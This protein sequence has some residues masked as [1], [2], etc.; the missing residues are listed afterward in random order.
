MWVGAPGSLKKAHREGATVS[1]HRRHPGNSCPLMEWTLVTPQDSGTDL[2]DKR[3]TRIEC[4]RTEAEAEG[5]GRRGWRRRPWDTKALVRPPHPSVG[6]IG[7]SSFLLTFMG[8]IA[9]PMAPYAKES[10]QQ[11]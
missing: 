5:G 4:R 3:A 8:I 11:N 9:H 10:Q 2:L 1:A 7:C 6:G